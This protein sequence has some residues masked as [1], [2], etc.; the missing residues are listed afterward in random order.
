MSDFDAFDD[1]PDLLGDMA[2]AAFH[3]YDDWWRRLIDRL[4]DPELAK[5]VAG[6]LSVVVV[7][8]GGMEKVRL[9]PP[10]WVRAYLGHIG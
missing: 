3:A 1:G 5:L 7:S 4:D 8:E 6:E 9:D 10:E 2:P